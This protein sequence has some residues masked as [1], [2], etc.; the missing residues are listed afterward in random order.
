MR[1][2]YDS[3]FQGRGLLY[4]EV[5]AIELTTFSQFFRAL[6]GVSISNKYRARR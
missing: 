2:Y 1:P 5:Y 6:V 4:F 3:K